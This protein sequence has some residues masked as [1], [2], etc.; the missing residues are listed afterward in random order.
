MKVSYARTLLAGALLTAS[1]HG[2]ASG[3]RRGG[4]CGAGT[5]LLLGGWN[6]VLGRRPLRLASRLLGGA[7]PG[8]SLGSAQLASRRWWLPHGAGP[9]GPRLDRLKPDFDLLMNAAGLPVS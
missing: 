3:T 9:L 5:R 8:L 7:A 1:L 4:R 2:S 6:L